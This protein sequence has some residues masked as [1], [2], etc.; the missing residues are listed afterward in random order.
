MDDDIKINID[1]EHKKTNKEI[2]HEY[3]AVSP[4]GSIVATFNSRGSSITITKVTNEKAE[5]SFDINNINNILRCSLAV[6]DIIDT[7]NDSCLVAISCVTDKDINT[8]EIEKDV[9]RQKFQNFT[10][11]LHL[12]NGC[13]L[14]I[15]MIFFVT[16]LEL[17][18]YY[19]FIITIL[20]FININMKL[21]D[22]NLLVKDDKLFKLSCISSEG[23]IKLFKFSFKNENDKDKNTIYSID[24][25]DGVVTFLKNFENSLNNN[26]TLICTNC[27]NIKKFNIKLDKNISVSKEGTYLLP[28]NLFKKLESFE[29]SKCK[30]NYLL[31]S[32]FQEYLMVDTSKNDYIQSIEIYNINNLKLV[33]IFH[34]NRGEEFLNSDDNE[35]GIFTI[36]T[37]SRLFAYSY[38]D[39]SVI[40]YLMESGLEIVSKKFDNIYKIKYIEFIEKDKRLF[41]TE[42]DEKNDWKFHIWFISGCLNDYFSIPKNDICSSDSTHNEHYNTLTKAYGKIVFYN[43]NQEEQFNVTFE[44]NNCGHEYNSCDLEPWNNSA[45]VCGRFL[46]NNKNDRRFLLI[47][48]QNSIQLWKSKSKNFVDYNDFKSF[49]NSNLVYI[50]ISD[51]KTKFLIEEDMVTVIT[52][53]C[54]SLAYL[55]KNSSI[56]NKKC[57][58]FISGI[59][60]IIKDFI[61]RYSDN[62]KLMEVQYP[63]MAYLI[64]SRSFSLIKYILFDANGQITGKLHKPQ[65]KYF[66]PY[67]KD[68]ELF[69]DLELKNE[70][71][72]STN[73]SKLK[74]VNDLELALEFCQERD[75]VM[76]GYLL[77]YYS[78]NSMTNIGWMINVIKILPYLSELS[79]YN[80]YGNYMDLL[81]YKPCFGEMKYNFPIERFEAKS[82]CQNTLKVFV[83]L[84]DLLSTNCSPHLYKKIREDIKPDIRMVPFINFTTHNDAKTKEKSK[85]IYT[86]FSYFWRLL[87]PPLYKK[88]EEKNLSSI[89]QFKKNKAEFF[90]IP[91]IEVAI[92]SKWNLA[93]VYWMNSLFLYIIFISIYSI[94]PLYTFSYDNSKNYYSKSIENCGIVM[95]YYIGIYLLIIEFMQMRKYGIKNYFNDIFNF[96]DLISIISGIIAF[97][98]MYFTNL[99]G[100]LMSIIYSIVTLILWFEMVLWIYFNLFYNIDP[101]EQSYILNNGS[102]NYTLTGPNQDYPFNGLFNSIFSIYYLS[103]NNPIFVLT[104][105]IIAIM[106]DEY[107]K[108]KNNGN[109]GLLMF[110]IELINDFEKLDIP[111]IELF[112]SP[113]IC[114]LQNPDLMKKWIEKSTELK[115]KKL[116]SWFRENVDK[117]NITYDGIDIISWYKLIQ[118]NRN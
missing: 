34:R 77:E 71:S 28:E 46:N 62:W 87:F 58:K 4:N 48:G 94:F 79:D 105:M 55:Y 85:N 112:D 30:W 78:E 15:L 49:E 118:K 16:Y 109:I 70:N 54:K 44:E 25:V 117:E 86:Y 115:E 80:Y 102:V 74:V 8:K 10:R 93:I 91:A 40:L 59:T 110:R 89:F 12:V 37:D 113:Y 18:L 84:T 73:D 99:N 26:A 101:L 32:S 96:I 22:R 67:Y 38:E 111:S 72:N 60:N 98:L 56:N 43:K 17:Y 75:A 65:K 52:H 107:K 11:L 24:G 114:Y 19:F 57:Q 95:F 104:N 29:D 88:L 1:D 90:S 51:T 116:Y 83:P 41:I 31:K 64:Y 92:N 100:F 82:I 23:M 81:L 45:N 9:P 13:C 6:S 14:L 39:N 21:I 97:S 103:T 106:N 3:I 35:P 50:L 42:E 69:D 63:L 5:K 7:K 68:L 20:V 61:K 27:V 53:A 76:L 47:N 33:N 36:S 66:S 2:E 108:A